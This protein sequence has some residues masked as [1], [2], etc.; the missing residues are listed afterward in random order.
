MT[1]PLR[2]REVAQPSN[3]VPAIR[4][5]DGSILHGEKGQIHSDLFDQ[6]THE[7]TSHPT[8]TLGED[9][10]G[11]SLGEGTQMMT[12]EEAAQWVKNNQPRAYDGTDRLDSY[13][14]HESLNKPK[15]RPTQ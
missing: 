1:C 12:R 13:M 8:R 15:S 2:G 3:L 11:F 7:Q 9:D 5:L 14:Y 10:L 6:L 4:G